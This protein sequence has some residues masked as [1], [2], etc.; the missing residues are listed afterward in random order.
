MSDA[1]GAKSAVAWPRAAASAIILRG[2]D[3]LLIERGNGAMRGL[4]SVP[5]G[6]IEPGEKA[7]DAARREV[8]EETHVTA[9]IV[10][11]LDVHDVIVRDA[12][13]ILTA[14]YVIA[15]HYGRHI[16]GQ[17]QPASDAAAAAYVPV[18]KISSLAMTAGTAALIMRACERMDTSMA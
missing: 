11:L 18:G 1:A 5:G 2:S 16:S 14:H 12:G 7:S 3:V 10:G 6:H 13:G 9:D 17:P 4:W 15:V 8:L